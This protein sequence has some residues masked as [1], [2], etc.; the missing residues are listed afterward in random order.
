M[1]TDPPTNTARPPVAN[2]QTGPVTIPCAAKLSSQ[3]RYAAILKLQLLLQKK[4]N[5]RQAAKYSV[6]TFRLADYCIS[7]GAWS[8]LHTIVREQW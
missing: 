6:S 8:L 4:Q 1:V 3:C 7:S 2:T 5:V